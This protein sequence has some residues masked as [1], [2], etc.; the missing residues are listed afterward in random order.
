MTRTKPSSKPSS[1]SFRLVRT[2]IISERVTRLLIILFSLQEI[3]GEK[4][5]QGTD[6]GEEQGRNQNPGPLQRPQGAEK[7]QEEEVEE[8]REAVR[9]CFSGF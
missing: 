1:S 6:R 2:E 4:E 9:T 7:L 8:R 3:S 5:I